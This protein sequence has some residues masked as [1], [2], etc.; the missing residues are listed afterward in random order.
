MEIFLTYLKVFGVG[1]A[2]CVL[3]QILLIKTKITSARILVI[4]LIAGIL[5]EAIGVFHYIKE[6][7]AAG[8]TIPIT[9]FGALL[10]KG[11]IEGAKADGILGLLGGAVKVAAV[12]LG[13]TI[14]FS[15]FAALVANPKTK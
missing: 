3:A 8:A 1:G 4:F 15:Y 14:V 9:G 6:F 5:L 12:G 13:A 10:A 11:A 7:A 2:L